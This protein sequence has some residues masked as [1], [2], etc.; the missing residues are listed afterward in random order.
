MYGEG[1][2]T[3]YA[4]Q[5]WRAR[6]NVDTVDELKVVAID[7]SVDTVVIVLMGHEFI[8]LGDLLGFLGL[9][10]LNGLVHRVREDGMTRNIV[11]KERVLII[12]F[13]TARERIVGRRR[14][15]RREIHIVTREDL[16]DVVTESGFGL[17]GNLVEV[18]FV[19]ALQVAASPRRSNNVRDAR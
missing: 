7:V 9:I 14:V 8:V 6:S 19:V 2:K 17:T 4:H 12:I 1:K 16:V 18:V 3:R 11:R 5:R 15:V 10:V 13:W